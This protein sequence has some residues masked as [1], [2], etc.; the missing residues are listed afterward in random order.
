MS[1]TGEKEK[2]ICKK[3]EQIEQGLRL[4]FP[5]PTCSPGGRARSRDGGGSSGGWDGEGGCSFC[6]APSLALPGQE[7]GGSRGQRSA[8]DKDLISAKTVEQFMSPAVQMKNGPLYFCPLA[9]ILMAD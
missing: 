4:V 5:P 7:W 1:L 2:E 9:G 3:H 6:S 8:S